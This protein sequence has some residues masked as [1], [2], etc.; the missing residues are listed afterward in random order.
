MTLMSFSFREPL[1]M[2]S[3]SCAGVRNDVKMCEHVRVHADG[4]KHASK[5]NEHR[6]SWQSCLAHAYTCHICVH[7]HTHTLMLHYGNTCARARACCSHF[8]QQASNGSRY[9]AVTLIK[10]SCRRICFDPFYS[11]VRWSRSA[12]PTRGSKQQGTAGLD[13]QRWRLM[14]SLISPPTH[15]EVTRVISSICDFLCMNAAMLNS[16]WPYNSNVGHFPPGGR[17]RSIHAQNVTHA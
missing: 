10:A 5:A 1:R 7:E 16:C 9:P 15:R 13:M 4:K 8:M 6:V 3:C 11:S 2:S 17:A 14:S 12:S